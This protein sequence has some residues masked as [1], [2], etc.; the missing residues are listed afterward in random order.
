MKK[1]NQSAMYKNFI[2]YHGFSILCGAGIFILCTIQIPPQDNIPLFP[3]FDKV[4]HFMMYFVLSLSIVLET[5]HV[6]TQAR[7]S[8]L[9]TFFIA[10]IISAI[11][12]GAIELIQGGLTDYRSADMM[13]WIFDMGGA[14]A[15]CLSIGLVRLA[16]R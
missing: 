15:A 7:K 3:N 14:V 11:F 6:K 10:L 5:I 4:V 9:R 2:K 12:G 16:F 8:I 1:E 13:D